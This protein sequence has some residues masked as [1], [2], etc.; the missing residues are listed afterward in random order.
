[1]TPQQ[2]TWI[3]VSVNLII[4]LAGMSIDVYLPSLPAMSQYFATSKTNVQLTVTF[5]AIALGI[6]QLLAGPISDANGRKKML[7]GALG[8]ESISLIGILLAPTIYLV[9]FF[10]F[11]QGLAAGFMMVPAR[12]II[13]DIFTGPE[14]RKKFNYVTITYAM[15]PIIA[16]F[17]G[18]YLQSYFGWQSCFILLLVYS[19]AITGITWNIYQETHTKTHKFL[20]HH[21][22]KNYQLIL[23]NVYFSMCTVFVGILLGCTAL[24][25]VAGPFLIQMSL[26]ESA[27]MFGRTALIMGFGWFLGNILNR[28][29]FNVSIQLKAK[30]GLCAIFLISL[31][32]IILSELNYFNLWVLIIPIFFITLLCGFLFSMHVAECLTMFPSHLAAS[33]NAGMFAVAWIIFSLFTV[34]ATFLKIH[35]LMPLSIAYLSISLAT[36]FIFY[37][38]LKPPLL[39]NK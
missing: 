21:L 26:H 2:K 23:K 32:M 10:R 16:P 4:F 31:I 24:Y 36:L 13:N 15:G 7:F 8:V 22:W 11:I 34:I 29:T 3:A 18:G 30:A 5:Y 12:A 39:S 35:S 14:L 17:I 19:V 1:M 25:N 27:I 6:A 37:V 33:A 9:I 20:I 28:F 38:Y